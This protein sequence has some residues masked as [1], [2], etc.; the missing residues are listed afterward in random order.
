MLLFEPEEDV[1]D[2]LTWGFSQ[3]HL[4]AKS[5]RQ[6]PDTRVIK[7]EQD[8]SGALGQGWVWEPAG[9]HGV[10]LQLLLPYLGN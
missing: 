10:S 7:G 4:K 8:S 5:H 1:A 6:I 3:N 9:S 2:S